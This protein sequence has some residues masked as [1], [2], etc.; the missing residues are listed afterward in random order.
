MCARLASGESLNTVCKTD[1]MPDKSTVFDWLRTNEVFRELYRIAKE[2][3]ADAWVEEIMDIA[4]DGTNDWMEVHDKDGK[5]SWKL[6]GEHVQRSR[7]R[8]DTR[9]WAASKMKPKKYGEKLELAGDP[10]NPLRHAVVE[11]HIVDH[12]PK[13]EG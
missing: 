13:T 8:V 4:D 11:M 9:K 3:C 10:A 1:G 2:E 5:S 6:N 12:R 7:L